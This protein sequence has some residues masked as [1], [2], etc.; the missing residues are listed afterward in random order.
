M[1]WFWGL[2]ILIIAVII[3]IEEDFFLIEKKNQ[4]RLVRNPFLIIFFYF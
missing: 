4:Y 2:H 1:F 3:E